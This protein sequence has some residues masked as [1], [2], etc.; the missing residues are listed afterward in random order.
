MSSQAHSHSSSLAEIQDN[1]QHFT[2]TS[3]A[4]KS[5][6]LKNPAEKQNYLQLPVRTFSLMVKDWSVEIHE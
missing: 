6:R 5:M 1:C 2:I 3:D 4:I